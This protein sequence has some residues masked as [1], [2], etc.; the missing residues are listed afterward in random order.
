[1]RYLLLSVLVVCMIGIMVPSVLGDE[2]FDR[3]KTDI[4]SSLGYNQGFPYHFGLEKDFTEEQGVTK[5]NYQLYKI[6][7]DQTNKRVGDLRFYLGSSEW[8][9]E[10]ADLQ[11]DDTSGFEN[12]FKVKIF[13]MH[14]TEPVM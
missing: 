8:W 3:K 10:N 1:M 11:E 7:D 14:K 4:L 5:A 6:I 12:I 13:L 9:D 2:I